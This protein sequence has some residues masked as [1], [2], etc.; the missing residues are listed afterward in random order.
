MSRPQ[1]PDHFRY[2]LPEEIEAFYRARAAEGLFPTDLA[3]I[4]LRNDA[5][6]FG[7]VSHLPKPERK[8]GRPR[9]APLEKEQAAMKL[10]MA[11]EVRKVKVPPP[12]PPVHAETR[13]VLPPIR[14]RLG[15]EDCMARK[16][17]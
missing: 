10:R 6:R 1:I 13:I 14:I 9:K 7:K 3:V 17:W 5:E 12:K 8:V 16:T 2:G 15:Y 4:V 11:M